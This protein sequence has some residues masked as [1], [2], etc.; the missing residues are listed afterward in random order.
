MIPRYVGSIALKSLMRMIG[1]LVGGALSVWLVSDYTSSLILFLSVTSLVVAYS[2]YKLCQFG[3]SMSPYA[4]HLT[5]YTLITIA[6]Y[7]ISDPENAWSIG[8]NR[9]EE[10]LLGVFAVL[11]V[12]GLF[13]PR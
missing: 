6:S 12:T 4:H 11:L 8:L 2:N 13:W 5:G 3:Q 9:T 10:T 7:G 1:T